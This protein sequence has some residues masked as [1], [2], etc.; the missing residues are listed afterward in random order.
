MDFQVEAD[1][2]FRTDQFSDY[3][4]DGPDNICVFGRKYPPRASC[5]NS[6]A[7]T[8]KRFQCGSVTGTAFARSAVVPDTGRSLLVVRS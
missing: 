6:H 1:F 7:G 4:A 2:S 8:R 3:R 5:L